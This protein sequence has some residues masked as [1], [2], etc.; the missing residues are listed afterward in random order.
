MRKMEM[1]ELVQ[2]IGTLHPELALHLTEANI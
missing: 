2:D 1:L